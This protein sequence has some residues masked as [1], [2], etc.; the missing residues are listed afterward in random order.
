MPHLVAA[1]DKFKG[2][3]TAA[4][5][6][7]AVCA[8]AH[9]A[10]WSAE[11]VP[12]ADG[13]E[14]TLDALGGA[15]RWTTV[16]GPLGPPVEAGWRLDGDEAIVEMARAS[17]LTLAGGRGRNDPIRATTRGTGELLAAAAAAGAR[18]VVVAVGG[19][20]TTDGGLGCLRAL[21]GRLPD[22]VAVEV[23][24]DV[25]VP[26]LAAASMFGPQKGATPAQV[27]RLER[28]LGRLATIYRHRFG[29]DVHSLPGA[30]A[31]GGLAGGLAAAGATLCRGFDLVADRVGLAGRIDGADLVVTGEGRYDHQSRHGKVVDGVGRAA[32]RA[33]V[34]HVVVAGEVEPGLDGH[35]VVSLSQR[36]GPGRARTDVLACVEQAVGS[37]LTINELENYDACTHECGQRG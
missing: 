20:A 21:G 2:T 37:I 18:R 6:A 35:G 3:A 11:A 28:R 12:M 19:S 30:G 1:P 29:V 9:G 33:G 34:A 26:F 13:G 16:T 8:G 25:D 10:G 17:G 23:A 5:V 14:G 24:V 22:G 32:A 31:A 15:N 27:A 7:A 36:F 4:E